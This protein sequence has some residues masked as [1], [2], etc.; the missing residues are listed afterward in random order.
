MQESLDTSSALDA[1]GTDAVLIALDWRGLPLQFRPG[2]AAEASAAVDGA[3]R[4]VEGVTAGIQQ[5][6]RAVCILQTVAPPAERLFGSLDRALEGRLATCW[7]ESMRGS[8]NSRRRSGCALLDVA[9]LAETVGVANWH[10][11]SEWNMAKVPFAQMFLAF[12]ATMCAAFGCA[13]RKEP[14]LPGARSR[15]HVVGWSDW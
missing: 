15:Q 4:Y 5:N 6:S 14:P 9:G 3:L 12:D 7:T 2:N 1:S 11:P 13:E 10:S 8:R